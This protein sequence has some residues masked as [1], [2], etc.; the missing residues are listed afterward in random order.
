M[1]L[2]TSRLLEEVIPTCI[3]KRQA[4]ILGVPWPLKHGW[5]DKLIGKRLSE[6]DYQKLK[7]REVKSTLLF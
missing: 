6:E 5:K 1:R 2:I 7:P 4:E 3:T